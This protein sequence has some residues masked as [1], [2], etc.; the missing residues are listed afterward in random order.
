M[1]QYVYIFGRTPDL[2]RQELRR[3]LPDGEIVDFSDGAL[4]MLRSDEQAKAVFFRLGGSVKCAVVTK[5]TPDFKPDYV[6][7][8]LNIDNKAIEFGISYYGI[9]SFP[10]PKVVDTVKRELEADGHKVRYRLPKNG[11]ALS[12]ATVGKTKI[13]EIIIVPTKAGYLF[14][15][16]LVVQDF[17]FWNR[18]DYGRPEADASLGMLPPKVARM[19]NNLAFGQSALKKT[20]LDPFCGMGT[21]LQDGLI[22]GASVIGSDNNKH[23]LARCQKNLDWLGK[24]LPGIS[25]CC[26]TLHLSDATHISGLLKEYSIDVIVTEPYMGPTKFGEGKVPLEKTR[27]IFRGLEKLYL[28]C[29]RDWS[30]I[31]KSKGMVAVCLPLYQADNRRL[32]QIK[33]IDTCRRLGYTKKLGPITYAREHA[34]IARQIYLL[35]KE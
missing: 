20:L 4:V 26:Q 17:D 16:T 19:L 15:R 34:V 11:V 29:L 21:I 33:V 13:Q 12:S 10:L 24:E 30:R 2:A 6:T 25:S 35:Q 32:I 3:I 22:Q 5:V 27:N 23:V 9:R 28:G 18:I 31:L 7:S 8:C 14:A 1:C